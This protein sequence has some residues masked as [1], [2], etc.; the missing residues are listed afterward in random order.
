[1]IGAF[2]FQGDPVEGPPADKACQR[3]DQ[4]IGV[5]AYRRAWHLNFTLAS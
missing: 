2:V 5:W 4:G 1:L 3:F